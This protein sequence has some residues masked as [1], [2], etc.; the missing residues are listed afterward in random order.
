MWVFFQILQNYED[1]FCNWQ[2]FG[3]Y[4]FAIRQIFIV[5]MAKFRIIILPIWSHCVLLAE[6]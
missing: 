5:V 2:I 4:I 6:V 1:Y 3:Q